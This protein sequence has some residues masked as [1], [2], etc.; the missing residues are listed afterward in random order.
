MRTP[1]DPFFVHSSLSPGRFP[2]RRSP[3]RPLIF[4]F[5][6][7]DGVSHT[8][9]PL[10]LFFLCLV[11]FLRGT[12]L[13]AQERLSATIHVSS[14]LLPRSNPLPSPL[15]PDFDLLSK[16]FCSISLENVTLVRLP[17]PFLVYVG[18]GVRFPHPAS[19]LYIRRRGWIMR[20]PWEDSFRPPRGLTRLLVSA[21]GIF[22]TP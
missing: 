3:L 7:S 19:H 1:F 15:F 6:A 22:L 17:I 12:F 10:F 2:G 5:L 11:V 18:V 8:S 21:V 9:S 4:S 20:T 14:P 16:V 13:T